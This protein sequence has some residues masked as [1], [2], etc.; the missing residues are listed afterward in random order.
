MIKND[1][2]QQKTT[3]KNTSQQWDS[4]KIIP[5]INFLKDPKSY[6]NDLAEGSRNVL[7]IFISFSRSCKRIHFYQAYLAR[8]CKLSLRQVNR[9][10]K[11]FEQ[12]GLIVK[13][14]NHMRNSYYR[15]TDML[16][17]PAK[18]L[19]K[20]LMA[21]CFFAF[22]VLLSHPLRPPFNSK[23]DVIEIRKKT[24]RSSISNKLSNYLFL[25]NSINSRCRMSEFKKEDFIPEIVQSLKG[26][27]LTWEQKFKLSAYP[28]KAL[29]YAFNQFRYS[30]TN[31]YGTRNNYSWFKYLCEDYCKREKLNP[32]WR[33]Y[34][35]LVDVYGTEEPK[36]EK[37]EM[38][39][40]T[41]ARQAYSYKLSPNYLALSRYNPLNVFAKQFRTYKSTPLCSWINHEDLYQLSVVNLV[42][43]SFLGYCDNNDIA[44]DEMLSRLDSLI[45]SQEFIELLHTFG[46]EDMAKFIMICLDA[47]IADQEYR[48][49]QIKNKLSYRGLQLD[50]TLKFDERIIYRTRNVDEFIRSESF[51]YIASLLGEHL[52]KTKIYKIVENWIRIMQPLP[53]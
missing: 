2:C 16:I 45:D 30:S 1:V 50:D 6:L 12:D 41:V 28:F 47:V 21:T 35:Q 9:I 42:N 53:N 11:K 4:P 20:V 25:N 52:F 43:R 17:K 39:E 51:E 34:Y 33:L 37:V 8:R 49:T 38:K 22:N 10:I 40:L 3:N 29:S 23:P 44:P 32:N 18:K 7:S 13:K 36:K 46:A 48:I 24:I 5:N 14:Y 26:L 19:L 31:I 27:N 15:V